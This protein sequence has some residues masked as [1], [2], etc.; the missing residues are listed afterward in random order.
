M[1]GIG[2]S[3]EIDKDYNLIVGLRIREVREILGMTREEF[4]EMCDISNSF[5]AAVEGGKKAVTSKT[6]FKICTA[7]NISADYII[8]G[9]QNGF[10]T[11]M[12][13]EMLNS[14]EKKQR[15]YAVRILREFI[16]AVSSSK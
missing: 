9:N 4:S 14:M 8:R 3:M 2:D 16:S 11:D 15:E 7:A 5:L 12:L 10:E 6:P 1:K 13:L